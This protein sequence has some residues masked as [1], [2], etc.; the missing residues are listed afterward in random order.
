MVLVNHTCLGSP[1]KR[2]IWALSGILEG[3]MWP[4]HLYEDFHCMYEYKALIKILYILEESN[5]PHFAHLS[6][7]N[8]FQNKLMEGKQKH[9]SHK[10]RGFN[11]QYLKEYLHEHTMFSFRSYVFLE[12]L[13]LFFCA[14]YQVSYIGSSDEISCIWF[15]ITFLFNLRSSY[16]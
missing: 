7:I 4:F 11:V 3:L 12:R 14:L 13:Q 9:I 2:T 8:F 1:D 15:L 10:L 16:E 6:Q 5:P